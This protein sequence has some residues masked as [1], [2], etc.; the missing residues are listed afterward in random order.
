MSLINQVLN[1]LEKRG[2][3]TDIGEATVRVVKYKRPGHARWW[4]IGLVSV[5]V[6]AAAIWMEWGA[7]WLQGV[8]AL[9]ADDVKKQMAGIEVASQPAVTVS[10]ATAMHAASS[11]AAAE[12]KQTVPAVPVS[13]PVP[14]IISVS[15]TALIARGE[16]QPLTIIGNHFASDATVTLRT[17]RGKVITKRKIVQ[18]DAEKIVISANF[19]NKGGQWSVE[20]NNPGGISTSPFAFVVQGEPKAEADIPSVAAATG[21]TATKQTVTAILDAT[22]PA[23]TETRMLAEG[24]VN[25]KM[26]QL[27]PQQQ[28]E[29][30]F[31]RAY[32]LLQQGQQAAAI[33][34]FEAALLLDAAHIQARQTLVRL[35]LDNRRAEDAERVLQEGV[36]LV[37]R[38]SGF[39][40]LLARMQVSRNELDAAWATIQLSLPYASSDAEYIGFAAA[41]VQRLK[42]HAEAIE[43]YSKALAL[44]PRHAVWLMG[45]GISLRAEQRHDEARDAFRQALEQN[46]LNAELKA[47]VQQQ[48]KEL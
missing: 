34:G 33:G 9:P 23:A 38:H 6:L 12:T 43:Y 37:P 10:L 16:V 48:L 42:R 1:D 24:K 19:G 8:P 47:F 20:V 4:W 17:P 29:N 22:P 7:A 21:A 36:R 5:L 40:M 18:Q 30:E 2:V 41:L 13:P 44:K 35:L 28:A 26:T 27:T 11:V 31:R 15:P 39:A 3:S 25:K 45:M 32:G 46:T 14:V